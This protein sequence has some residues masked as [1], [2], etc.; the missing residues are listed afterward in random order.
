M[1]EKAILKD[2]QTSFIARGLYSF[3]N[4]KYLFMVMEYMKGGDLAQ[5]LEEFGYFIEDMAKYYIA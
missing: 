2:L 3:K 4:R 1:N 5:L